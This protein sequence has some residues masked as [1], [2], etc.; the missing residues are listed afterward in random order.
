MMLMM[1]MG[2]TT[3]EKEMHTKSGPHLPLARS[4]KKTMCNVS[5]DE[6]TVYHGVMMMSFLRI[7]TCIHT[8]SPRS[9]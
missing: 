8:L 9:A 3:T 6:K 1:I 5:D 2:E 4:E 7:Y